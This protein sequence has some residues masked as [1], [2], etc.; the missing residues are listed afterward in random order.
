MSKLL[1]ESLK[2]W[3]INFKRVLKNLRKIVVGNKKRPIRNILFK[4]KY[5]LKYLGNN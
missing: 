4:T 2:T 5:S 3:M 1:E